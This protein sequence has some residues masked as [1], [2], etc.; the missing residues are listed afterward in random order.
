MTTSRIVVCI[1]ALALSTGLVRAHDEFQFKGTVVKVQTDEKLSR[2]FG[3]PIVRLTLQTTK[4]GRPLS[5]NISI[6]RTTRIDRNGET[7]AVS[8]LTPGLSVVVDA[9]G[10]SYEDLDALRIQIVTSERAGQGG[11]RNTA[12]ATR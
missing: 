6:N 7:R 4:D 12:N 2:M 10:D 1:V 11:A 5:L 3:M 8:A 9:T